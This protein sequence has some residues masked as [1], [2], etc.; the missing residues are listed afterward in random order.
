PPYTNTVLQCFHVVLSRP[1]PSSSLFPYT[2]LFRSQMESASHI[3]PEVSEVRRLVVVPFRPLRTDPDSDFLAISLP[4]AITHSL[5]GL[6]SEEH[7]S[8]LQSLRH[9][10]CRLL[11]ET[12]K[13]SRYL[14]QR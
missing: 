12:K 3:G 13:H 5:A 9:L 1:P 7:T 4:D 11:L 8:E 14:R 10:V 2:T 6:R